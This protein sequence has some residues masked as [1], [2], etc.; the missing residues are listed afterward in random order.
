[1][2]SA[3]ILSGARFGAVQNR[4]CRIALSMLASSYTDYDRLKALMI[5]QLEYQQSG[6]VA[7]PGGN[8]LLN[9]RTSHTRKTPYRTVMMD[10]FRTMRSGFAQHRLDCWI[11]TVVME[12]CCPIP[13]HQLLAEASSRSA[14]KAV[15]K[16]EA[17]G[18]GFGCAY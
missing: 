14:P 4:V 1:M 3:C 11:P 2:G 6:K 16:R 9:E 10:G 18:R 12:S 13:C 17:V 15:R 7:V 5:I 8:V